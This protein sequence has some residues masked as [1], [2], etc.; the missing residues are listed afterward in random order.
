MEA[1][2]TEIIHTK[3]G[4]YYFTHISKNIFNEFDYITVKI[5]SPVAGKIEKIL[6]NEGETASYMHLYP[7]LLSCHQKQQV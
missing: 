1:T 2:R 7:L 5:P 4:L 6:I 3:C